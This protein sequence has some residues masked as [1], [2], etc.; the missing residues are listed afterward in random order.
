M[1]DKN[2]N[3]GNSYEGNEDSKNKK[4]DTATSNTDKKGKGDKDQNAG[5]VWRG[6]E[7]TTDSFE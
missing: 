3:T 7:N 1:T 4:K 5:H 2:K 6:N